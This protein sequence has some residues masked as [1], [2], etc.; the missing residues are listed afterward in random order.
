MSNARD[1]AKNLKT[2]LNVAAAGSIIDVQKAGSTVGQVSNI[3]NDFVVGS[4]TGSGAGLRFDGTNNMMYP[5]NSL[6]SSRDNAVNLGGSSVRFKDLYLG[7]GVY[8]GGTGASNH[9][10]DY[11]EGTYTVNVTKGGSALP[12]NIRY[13]Y[14]VKVGD[15]FWVSFYWYHNGGLSSQTNNGTEYRMSLPFNVRSLANGAYQ[16]VPAGYLALNSSNVFNNYPHRWQANNTSFL[17][18][19]GVN[20]ATAHTSGGIEFS[21]SGCFRIA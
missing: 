13:G 10:D 8:L 14:Y 1:T 19:Y 17:A 18:L 3:G 6:G 5:S 2:G 4:S 20:Y 11:E 15:M 12:V 16:S 21:G 7:G 9:L